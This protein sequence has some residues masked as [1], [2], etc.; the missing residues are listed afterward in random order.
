MFAIAVKSGTVLLVTLILEAAGLEA[1]DLR[2]HHADEF[3]EDSYLLVLRMLHL[4][5]WPI[6]ESASFLRVVM[7]I[8]E[9]KDTFRSVR[10]ASLN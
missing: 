8:D 1:K 9:S 10:F 4:V 7:N 3:R 6:H 5:V 2:N